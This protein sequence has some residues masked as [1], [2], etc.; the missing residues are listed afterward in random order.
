MS[1]IVNQS[2][3]SMAETTTLDVTVYSNRI[4]LLSADMRQKRK[5]QNAYKVNLLT[6]TNRDT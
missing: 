4:N 1:H 2:E 5:T 6:N 3:N